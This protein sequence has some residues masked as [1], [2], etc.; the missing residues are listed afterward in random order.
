MNDDYQDKSNCEAFEILISSRI[1]GEIGRS[2]E[3][4]LDR[5]L[6]SCSKC[7][8]LE[9]RFAKVDGMVAS[10][11][12]INFSSD[13]KAQLK[14]KSIPS[15]QFKRNW[16][17]V[18]SLVGAAAIAIVIIQWNWTAPG[19]EN[20]I[21]I[22]TPIVSLSEIYSHRIHDQEL[23]RESLEMDLRTLK[24]QLFALN[25]STDP[26]TTDALLIRI[27]NLME[28]IDQAKVLN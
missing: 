14:P 11:A 26:E 20:S 16:L 13:A 17:S 22:A 25:E 7:R 15:I 6:E 4:E 23:M 10:T 2:E 27:N 1:D 18:A 24:L 8:L 9:D 5:H 21:D 19:T 3:I 12:D 28:K